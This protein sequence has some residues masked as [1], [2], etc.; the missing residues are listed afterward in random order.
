MSEPFSD[1]LRRAIRESGL[2]RYAIFVRT[3]IDQATLSKFMK[4]ERGLSL[5]AI[6]KLMDELGLEIRPRKRKAD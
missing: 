2:T 6:D 1:Q 5:S 3:K 4:G